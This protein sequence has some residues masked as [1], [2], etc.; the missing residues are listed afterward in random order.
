M[1]RTTEIHI[2]EHQAAD[3]DAVAGEGVAVPTQFVN[4]TV[5]YV[6]EQNL[7]YVAIHATSTTDR[8]L[9]APLLPV[10]APEGCSN[11]HVEAVISGR[12]KEL[13]Q[14][15]A[16]QLAEYVVGHVSSVC[17]PGGTSGHEGYTPRYDFP[18]S[19]APMFLRSCSIRECNVPS[20]ASE[21]FEAAVAEAGE[22]Q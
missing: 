14:N 16:T 12:L 10:G 7:A 21:D 22:A 3:H 1:N 17:D 20:A 8:A 13:G 2:F 15:R 19:G 11:V 18:Q 9:I 5:R 4:V 6:Q